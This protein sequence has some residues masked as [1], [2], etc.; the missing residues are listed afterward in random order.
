MLLDEAERE[1]AAV[2]LD[3]AVALLREEALEEL[4]DLLLVVDDE[5]ELACARRRRRSPPWSR[6]TR[7]SSGSW[8]TLETSSPMAPKSLG[9]HAPTSRRRRDG[10][11]DDDGRLGGRA[12]RR[13]RARRAAGSRASRRAEAEL[14][15]RLCRN[16][17]T[18]VVALAARLRVVRRGDRLR[19]ASSGRRC[20]G[21]PSC[22]SRTRARRSPSCRAGR[23]SPGRRDRPARARA[24]SGG[25]SATSRGTTSRCSRTMATCVRSIP[26]TPCCSESARRA[27]S[28][29]HLALV[30]ELRGE[31]RRR[32]RSAAG[33]CSA[34]SSSCWD[35]SFRWSRIL[36][37]RPLVVAG[38]RER[39]TRRLRGAGIAHKR[40]ASTP[41]PPCPGPP[42][43]A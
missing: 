22:P 20:T 38:H 9:R 23:P 36:P 19:G 21:R 26:G 39:L 28:S 7:S 15:Q 14:A 8:V 16:A 1:Q 33:P 6:R 25:V 24:G 5:D 35:T 11:V 31:R 32:D 43:A 34:S 18:Q 10:V 3:D 27:S 42:P 40:Y 41:I 17:R 29:V 13:G 37:E 4:P 12:A 30:D 2:R